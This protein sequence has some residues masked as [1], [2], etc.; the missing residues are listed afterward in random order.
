MKGKNKM[1]EY[2][3]WNDSKYYVDDALL[4]DIELSCSDDC[5]ITWDNWKA[6]QLP[7]KII[8]L[9]VLDYIF[10]GNII[11]DCC[12]YEQKIKVIQIFNELLVYFTKYVSLEIIQ[13]L[14]LFN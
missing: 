6:N 9:H 1:K 11:N 14:D 12:Q 3:N 2:N 5:I 7:K 4:H 13:Y 8:K 10:I